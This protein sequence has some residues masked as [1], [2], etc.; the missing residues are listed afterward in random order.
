[1]EVAGTSGLR[2]DGG[3]RGSPALCCG[4]R[5]PRPPPRAGGGLTTAFDGA[6]DG[7]RGCGIA[8]P[9]CHLTGSGL[10]QQGGH[11]GG[12]QSPFPAAVL[13]RWVRSPP[14]CV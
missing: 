12:R 14:G 10:L 6:G 1:M 4:C 8:V 13:P 11:G 2:C 5:D 7:K 9:C 3:S